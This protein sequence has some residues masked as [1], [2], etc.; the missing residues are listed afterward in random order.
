MIILSFHSV[1]EHILGTLPITLRY[2]SANSVPAV[3]RFLVFY[4]FPYFQL[5]TRIDNNRAAIVIL[6]NVPDF[7]DNLTDFPKYVY[8]LMLA[9]K[10]LPSEPQLHFEDSEPF[11]R[12]SVSESYSDLDPA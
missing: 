1:G 7:R 5:I 2:L 12:H 4:F 9:K 10:D 8:I 3:T 11:S 6:I